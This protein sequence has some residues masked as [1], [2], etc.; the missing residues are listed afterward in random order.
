MIRKYWWLVAFALSILMLDSLIMYW[1]EYMTTE[2][3]KCRNMNSVN[4]LKLVNCNNL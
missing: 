1:V 4:P 2:I 3:D